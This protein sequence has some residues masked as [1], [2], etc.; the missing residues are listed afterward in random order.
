MAIKFTRN[1]F[2]LTTNK[3]NQYTNQSQHENN[4]Y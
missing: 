2:Y 1:S 4:K 3:T